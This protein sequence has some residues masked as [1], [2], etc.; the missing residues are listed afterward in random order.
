MSVLALMPRQNVP[1]LDLP[2]VGG[3]R[4][5]LGDPP[6]PRFDLIVFY[7][8]LHCPV[9]ATYLFELEQLTPAFAE[10]G[11]SALAVSSD[12]ADRAHAMAV[13]VGARSLRVAYGLSL[14]SARRWGLFLSA[15][16]GQTSIG[17]EEPALFSEP[18]VFLVQPDGRLYYAAVQ[19][20]PFARP[21]F[22]DLLTALDFAIRTDYPARGEFAG[23]YGEAGADARANANA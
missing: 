21:N 17:V 2:L 4:F 9:C 15:S 19:T 10:R 18:G 11:V 8:G 1:A 13:K 3:G 12:N 7:R 20:M 16:R 6:A 23:P 14:A 5:L 22:K